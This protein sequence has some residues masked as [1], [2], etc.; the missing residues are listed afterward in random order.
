[1]RKWRK[2]IIDPSIKGKEYLGI[3]KTFDMHAKSIGGYDADES[4][5]S[6]CAF[7]NKYL[8]GGTT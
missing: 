7:F 6:K 4:Y 5:A 1:M 2:Y 8:G 3:D